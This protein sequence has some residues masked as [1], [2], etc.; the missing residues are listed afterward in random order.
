MNLASAGTTLFVQLTSFTEAMKFVLASYGSRGDV[1]PFA[2][3][4]RELARRGH[5]VRLA[6]APNM[7]DFAESAGLSA[8]AF[9][10]DPPGEPSAGNGNPHNPIGMLTESMQHFARAC[11]EWGA[12]LT[13]LADGADLLLTGRFEQ[14]MATNVAE[15]YGIPPA[16]L[17]F[18][19]EPPRRPEDLI[20]RITEEAHDAQRRTLGLPEGTGSTPASLDIQAYDE[21]CLPELAADHAKPRRFVGALTVELS[22]DA[23]DEVLSW[24]AAGTPPIYFGFGSGVVFPSA[25]DTVAVIAAAC[26]QL[27]ERALI[28]SGPNDFTQMRHPTTSRSSAGSVTRSSYRPVARSSITGAPAP[29][30]RGCG[31]GSPR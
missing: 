2:A 21:L 9:G 3:V 25:A 19:P 29:R 28:Y 20:G 16:A 17:H 26:A 4:G 22:T 18:F 11:A 31:P 12:T 6:V 13:T 30:P 7:L 15:Y 27:G 24:I 23:D 14:G 10:P 8:V 5:D 1:E